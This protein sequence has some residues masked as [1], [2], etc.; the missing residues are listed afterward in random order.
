MLGLKGKGKEERADNITVNQGWKTFRESGPENSKA[1]HIL[2]LI[3]FP[4][5]PR[6][7][8]RLLLLRLQPPPTVALESKLPPAPPTERLPGLLLMSNAF[9]A[10]GES[11]FPTCAAACPFNPPAR[12][13]ALE[14]G[15]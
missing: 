12:S 4:V 9:S 14:S 6:S 11:S 3:P 10:R 13:C 2:L 7:L 1:S 5:Q 15:A 8:T